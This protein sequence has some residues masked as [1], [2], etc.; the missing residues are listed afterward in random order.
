ML[1]AMVSSG[2]AALKARFK[3]EWTLVLSCEFFGQTYHVKQDQV[4]PL[5]G[6]DRPG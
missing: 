6:G 2:E 1:D 5:A 3:A 4:D